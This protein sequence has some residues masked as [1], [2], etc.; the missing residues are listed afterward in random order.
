MSRHI[1]WRCST[2]SFGSPDPELFLEHIKTH[3]FDY[4]LDDLYNVRELED[5]EL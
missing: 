4:T 3:G 1:F 5:D 2:C